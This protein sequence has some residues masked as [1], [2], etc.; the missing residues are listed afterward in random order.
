MNTEYEFPY[1]TFS[2]KPVPVEE[3]EICILLPQSKKYIGHFTFQNGRPVFVVFE[4]NRFKQICNVVCTLRPI[5]TM[6]EAMS[7]L[8]GT[9][10]YGSIFETFFIIEDIFTF[11]DA[12]LRNAVYKEKILHLLKVVSLNGSMVVAEG[13]D[14]MFAASVSTPVACPVVPNIFAFPVIVRNTGQTSFDVDEV[15]Y[16]IHHVQYR[17]LHQIRPI[18]NISISKRGTLSLFQYGP[19][20]SFSGGRT[21]GGSGGGDL[22]ASS[23]GNGRPSS[24]M[25]NV[26]SL[27]PHRCDFSKPQYKKKTIFEVM[28]DYP[29]DIYKLF[30]Y[31]NMILAGHPTPNKHV[32]VDIAY[33]PDYKTSV[34][35]NSIFRKISNGQWCKENKNIDYIEESDDEEEFENMD[36]DKYVDVTKKVN[37][38]CYFHNKFKKW[39]PL[40]VVDASYNGGKIV[41][42]SNL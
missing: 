23:G 35:M 9:V 19:S 30:A 1:E 42:I 40:T 27:H 17:S 21:L 41:P 2:D 8:V 26:V 39:V 36:V 7:W 25:R 32:Y 22:L 38:L 28:A 5:C 14:P 6:I 20:E 24:V 37:M 10:V 12:S 18:V 3:Y 4:L 16:P 29:F 11:R 31:N 33:I 15:A 34:F 13:V